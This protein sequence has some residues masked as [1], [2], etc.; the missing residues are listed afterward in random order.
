MTRIFCKRAP[1]KQGSFSKKTLQFRQPTHPSNVGS[2]ALCAN[3]ARHMN[4][5]SSLKTNKIPVSDM[6]NII[7]H[8]D[9]KSFHNNSLRQTRHGLFFFRN[10]NRL[11]QNVAQ[12]TVQQ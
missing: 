2:L 8:V 7:M 4:V 1:Q 10:H 11:I 6:R 3:H 9:A 12:Q 5:Y